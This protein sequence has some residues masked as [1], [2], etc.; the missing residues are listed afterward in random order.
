MY[1]W[2]TRGGRRRSCKCRRAASPRLFAAASARP[3]HFPCRPPAASCYF[4]TFLYNCERER[5]VN[6]VREQT[7]SFW[8]HVLENRDT[9]INHLYSP[10]MQVRC[11]QRMRLLCALCHVGSSHAHVSFQAD[12]LRVSPS[13]RNLQ[14]W[15]GYYVRWAPE[16]LPQVRS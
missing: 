6:N 3:P 13:M 7:L 8:D 15:K 11:N 1:R 14:L 16:Y 10:A 5:T 12:V 2:D 4:G 9:Y